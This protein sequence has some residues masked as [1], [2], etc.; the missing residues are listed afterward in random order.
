[1]IGPLVVPDTALRQVLRAEPVE[2]RG[3]ALRQ[4]QGT[5]DVS[6]I[7]TG[8]AGG[9]LGLA[10]RDMPGVRVVAV[11]SALRD[12]DDLAGNAARVASAAGELDESVAV[13]VEIPYAPGWERAVEEVEAAGLLGKIRTGSPDNSGTPPYAQLAEQ[14]SV[15]VEADLPFKATAGLH[16]AQ[17]TAGTDPDRPTQ[18]GFLNLLAAV[19]A[20][21]E[22][23]SVA[24]AAD[25]A[26]SDRSGGDRRMERG[27]GRP[28]APPVPQLRLLRR[29]RP[30]ARPGRARAGRGADMSGFTDELPYGVFSLPGQAPRVGVAIGERVLDVGAALAGGEVDPADFAQPSLNAFLARGPEA[31][32]ATRRRPAAAAGRSGGRWN[33]TWSR[34]M[35]RAAAPAHRGRRLRRLLRLGAP[36]QQRGPDVPAGRSAADA[37][38]EAHADRLPRPRRHGG[39]LRHR[40]RPAP[41]PDQGAERPGAASSGRAASWTSRPSWA[42]WSAWARRWE[43]RCR[44]TAS[45]STSSAW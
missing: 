18:H 8:G 35:R 39:G 2:V 29:A 20:L 4:A 43:R 11:E 13:F 24:E 25:S 7:N 34:S 42:G 26:A 44:S 38:L 9:L 12:L 36:R 41:R 23:A 45:A 31:W 27:D 14:L 5:L 37:E 22:G 40:R 10:R 30:G 15:L 32:A 1:M 28:G 33:R 17:P 16:H 21:V 19:E 6:V 3:E